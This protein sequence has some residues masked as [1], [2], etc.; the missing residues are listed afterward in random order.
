MLRKG[1]YKIDSLTVKRN[2]YVPFDTFLA[3]NDSL[4]FGQTKP[5]RRCWRLLLTKTL[6][7]FEKR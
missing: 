3:Y 4:Y 5:F 1:I 7:A 2:F 6:R